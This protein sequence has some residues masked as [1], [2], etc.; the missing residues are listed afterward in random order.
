MPRTN[1][2]TDPGFEDGQGDW[3]ASLGATLENAGGHDA[4]KCA[5]L[6]KATAQLSGGT[7]ELN[8]YPT[9]DL[10]PYSEVEVSAY[11]N[12][13]SAA[14][15]K[16]ACYASTDGATWTKVGEVEGDSGDTEYKLVYFGNYRTGSVGD[17][18]LR[19]VVEAPFTDE[20][21]FL[22]DDV[23]GQI[24]FVEVEVVPIGSTTVNAFSIV[25]KYSKE[26]MLLGEAV[27]LY[28]KGK[29]DL[30]QDGGFLVNPL[31]IPEL[32]KLG[33]KVKGEADPA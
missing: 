7:L 29:D 24:N 26:E 17:F 8:T 21:Y 9:T 6:P 20:A 32:R 13:G 22:L 19:F 5:K 33:F 31:Y 30:T 4:A 10:V 28:S 3:T 1:W 2:V 15:M 16:L 18:V 11:V 12:V 14:S 25:D 27:S 23:V